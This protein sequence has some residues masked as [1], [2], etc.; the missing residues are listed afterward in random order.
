LSLREERLGLI[1]FPHLKTSLKQEPPQ[2]TI[3]SSRHLLEPI[4]CL[5]QLV[6]PVG[7]LLTLK[8]R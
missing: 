5:P 8:P 7:V 2:P 6:H 1:D 4:Q 3:P